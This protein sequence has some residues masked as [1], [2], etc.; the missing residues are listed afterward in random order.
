MSIAVS[1]LAV[2]SPSGRSRY[3]HDLLVEPLKIAIDD[4]RQI[5]EVLTRGQRQADDR[6][7]LIHFSV[8][9]YTPHVQG[10]LATMGLGVIKRR[11]DQNFKEF[12]K[13]LKEMLSTA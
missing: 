7:R 3:L 2:D 12:E 11:V 9:E 13:R 4:K 8:T 6:L 10:R 5:V 1:V